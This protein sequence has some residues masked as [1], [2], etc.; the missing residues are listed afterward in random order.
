MSE[1]GYRNVVRP[2]LMANDKDE[3]AR[4][5]A[6]RKAK[7]DEMEAKREEVNPEASEEVKIKIKRIPAMPTQ[8]EID[9]HCATHVPFRDWCEFCVH[10]K[11]RDDP[12]FR[13]KK[14]REIPVP[15]IDID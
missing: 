11:A 1:D 15:E 8:A 4:V 5:E 6:I 3:A 2:Q 12:H 13:A 9:E 7:S 14:Q 10:G